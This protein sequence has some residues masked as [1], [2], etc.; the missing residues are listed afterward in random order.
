MP[1]GKPFSLS[2]MVDTDA[3]DD[4]LNANSFP[5]PDSGQE[6]VE[7][8]KR[9]PS[10]PK[11]SAKRF[12][13]PKR[14][15]GG[16]V[17]PKATAAPKPK[18]GRKRAPLKEQPNNQNM[19]DTEYV[20]EFAAHT[21]GEARVENVAEPKPAAKRKAQDN[22]GGRPAKARAIEHVGAA[23]D[24]EFEYT[25][26]AVRQT[27]VE[28]KPVTGKANG[29]K[30]QALVEP[31][32]EKTIPETQVQMDTDT[33]AG[34]EEL[35]EDYET[36]PQSVVRRINNARAISRPRQAPLGR[37]R[38]GS[39]SDTERV[40]GDVALR[41]KLGDMTRRFETVDLRYRTL[42]D[43]RATEAE[44]NYDR[45]KK[46]SDINVKGGLPFSAYRDLR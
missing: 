36:V 10:R 30:R 46:Q 29:T 15:S 22:K 18:A 26:T 17:A 25:P 44:A 7:A 27:R 19:V 21:D 43:S 14:L 31:R 33:S 34:Q 5:T 28:K 2:G 38:A 16:S 12:T 24:G 11:A 9:K 3:E 45:L 23:K 32:Q 42:K 4:A 8:P 35:E 40:V 41:R 1:K 20:D 6:N 13:K 37:R 39:A